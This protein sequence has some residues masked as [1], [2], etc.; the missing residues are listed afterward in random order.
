MVHSIVAVV[1]LGLVGPD[2]S[3]GA[4]LAVAEK[5]SVDT[6][7]AAGNTAEC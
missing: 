5:Q 1:G 6:A 7:E 3:L 4:E 2:N